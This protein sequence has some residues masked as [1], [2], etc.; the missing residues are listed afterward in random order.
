VNATY[1]VIRRVQERGGT[2]GVVPFNKFL[3]PNW[4]PSTAPETVT[5]NHLIAQIDYYCQLAGD[6]NHTGIGSDL[7]GGFGYPL[8][9]NG[10]DTI[11]D[12]QKLEPLLLKKG[13]TGTDVANIFGLN[14]K[15]H[16]ELILPE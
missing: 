12:L 14:W 1:A 4:T 15:K 3:I 10:M 2:I 6:S 5:I 7:D 16:L 11:S 13:Y 9:P 8:L